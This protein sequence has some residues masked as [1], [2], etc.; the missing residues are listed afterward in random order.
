[1]NRDDWSTWTNEQLEQVLFS[2]QPNSVNY[3]KAKYILEKRR[4]E[5]EMASKKSLAPVRPSTLEASQAGPLIQKL[6]K[7]GKAIIDRRPIDHN[8]AFRWKNTAQEILIK[9]FSSESNNVKGFSESVPYFEAANA[10][11]SWDRHNA[12]VM[13]RQLS[14]LESCSEQ[15]SMLAAAASAI[16][17]ARAQGNEIFLVHGQNEQYREQV[18]R[19]LEKF[20]LSVTILHE[21]PDR[22]RTVI[23]KFSDHSNVGFAV[24]LLTE[25]DRGGPKDRPYEDQ[26]LRARQNVLL[27]LGFFLGSLGREKV[28]ALCEDGVEI[29]SD[30]SGV[31]Y[32]PLDRGEAWKMR[33]AR[34]IQAAGIPLDMN[35]V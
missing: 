10:D 35:K 27:E 22:G 33:L 6:L 5:T 32:V 17:V 2:A 7:D 34:E 19:F 12:E 25:D 21:K 16:P 20:D 13:K 31:V 28:C 14:I 4:H 3:E 26:Q 15:L 23:E 1:M 18:A 9:C 24:V 29:P 8:E 30:Y 11:S